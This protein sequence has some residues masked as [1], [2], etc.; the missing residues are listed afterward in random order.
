MGRRAGLDTVLTRK[1]TAPYPAS[2]GDQQTRYLLTVNCFNYS[3][4]FAYA[5]ICILKM[6]QDLFHKNNCFE[7][8]VIMNCEMGR[9]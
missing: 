6:E 4:V 1:I 2:K 5:D 3:L 8:E 9:Y 7:L